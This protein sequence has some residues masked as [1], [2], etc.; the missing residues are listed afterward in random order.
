MLK[1]AHIGSRY[2]SVPESTARIPRRSRRGIPPTSVPHVSQLIKG[3]PQQLHVI[4]PLISAICKLRIIDP[5]PASGRAIAEWIAWRSHPTAEQRALKADTM[6]SAFAALK[7]AHAIRGKSQEGFS[8]PFI[9]MA[10][11]GHRRIQGNYEKKKAQPISKDLLKLITDPA[12][13]LT[14]TLS[15]EQR[16]KL[17]FD[18]SFKCEFAGFLRTAEVTYEAKE[19]KNQLLFERGHLLRRD[20]TFAENDEH[21]ILS[22]RGSKADTNFT[23]VEIFIS[24]ESEDPHCCPVKALRALV[25]LDPKPKNAP[26]F[27]LSTGAFNRKHLIDTLRA[28]LRAAGVANA[29]DFAGHSFRRGAAQHASDNGILDQDIQRLGRWSSDAFKGYFAIS[30][31]QK[32]LLHRRFL[33]GKATS[34]TQTPN[35]E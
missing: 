33:Q 18:T 28:R 9:K 19:T 26:L 15:S 6:V 5:Y 31:Y 1:F 2:P 3:N 20:I 21:A 16:N 27:S 32:F 11:D 23:G 12:P 30:T 24:S 14:S 35:H 13:V 4:C 29:K 7:W 17:N 8:S 25:T 34:F 10:I 22:L